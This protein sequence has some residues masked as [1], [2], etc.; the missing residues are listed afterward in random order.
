M[1]HRKWITAAGTALF[2]LH[3]TFN[4]LAGTWKQD[5]IGWWYCEDNGTY[6]VN[7]WKWIDGNHDG[8]A[9]CFGERFEL[10]LDSVES[11]CRRCRPK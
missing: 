6:P 4:V 9:E 3:S 8:I 1:K 11:K 2:I 7:T 10:L 5:D